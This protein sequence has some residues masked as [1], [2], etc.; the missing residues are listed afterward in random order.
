MFRAY[1]TCPDCPILTHTGLYIPW[2]WV[3]WKLFYS[4]FSKKFEF[5]SYLWEFVYNLHEAT[6]FCSWIQTEVLKW[7]GN[8][9][10]NDILS[11]HPSRVIMKLLRNRIAY[12]DVVTA[13]VHILTSVAKPC[14]RIHLLSPVMDVQ[15]WLF[16]TV[17]AQ[18]PDHHTEATSSLQSAA[19]C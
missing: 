19:T 8:Y 1:R 5:L 9:K 11:H 18:S 3:K 14:S 4:N 7:S 12:R 17:S 10:K 15:Q 6:G 16:F 13:H 2:W